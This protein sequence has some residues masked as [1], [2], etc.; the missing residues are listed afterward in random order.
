MPSRNSRL[1]ALGLTAAASPG[2]K[3]GCLVL[4]RILLLFIAIGNLW[5]QGGRGRSFVLTSPAF[6]A[7]DMIPKKFTC[8]GADISPGLTWAGAPDRTQSLAVIADDPDAP[9]GTWTHWIVW[10]IRPQTTIPE[11][12]AKVES[13]SN[14]I[15]QGRNDFKN[16]GYGGPCP[17]PG[18][19]HRYFF[20]LYAL[21]SEL[22][23]K[24]GGDRT[25]LEHAM[26]GHVL[27]QAEL[28]GRYGR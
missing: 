18:K 20:R 12:V 14:G 22:E 25:E 4:L 21:D 10:N 19:P 1:K 27:A 8:D 15:R 16:I 6:A 7:G 17:P 23:I 3:E 11:A 26:K 28:M 13:L 9:A 2:R 24:A 5:A